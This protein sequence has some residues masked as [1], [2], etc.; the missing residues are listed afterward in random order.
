V[1]MDIGPRG[2]E[3]NPLSLRLIGFADNIAPT[4]LPRGVRFFSETGEEFAPAPARLPAVVP[5]SSGNSGETSPQRG[6]ASWPRGGGKPRPTGAPGAARGPTPVGQGFSPATPV[7]SGRV[8]VVVE[9]FDR[10]DGNRA[11]RRLGV[12][13]LGYQVLRR[14]LSPV[15][16][17]EQP[18]M[19]L[20]FD[21]LP[22]DPE[23][24]QVVYAEGSGI[25][26]YGNKTTR[27]RYIVTNALIE[28]VASRGTWD[29]SSLLA[30]EYVVR[31]LA[32]DR[33][34]NTTTRDVP[35]A[36]R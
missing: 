14:D 5:G 11:N 22:S 16:G 27:F 9:A 29:T 8:S 26:V 30:G 19:S 20:V 6:W 4:I 7:L 2:A 23:A 13:A 24:P 33:S 36:I 18:R 21:R 31:I 1:H 35:V 25:T 12:Y 34:G 10:V 32:A 15:P 17:F 28:G 3:I